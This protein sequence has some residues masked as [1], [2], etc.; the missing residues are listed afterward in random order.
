[1]KNRIKTYFFSLIFILLSASLFSNKPDSV[2]QQYCPGIS[3]IHDI[4]NF[5]YRTGIGLSVYDNERNIQLAIIPVLDVL[6]TNLPLDGPYGINTT[7]IFF[8]GKKNS[9][10]LNSFVNADHKIMFNKRISNTLN[11]KKFNTLHEITAGY[12]I[13][14]R[15]YRRLFILN[16]VNAGIVL[17]RIFSVNENKTKTYTGTEMLISFTIRYDL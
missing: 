13:E 3:F 1:M 5:G 14:V 17:D 4:S 16:S 15:V 6:K 10:S 9:S 11:D 12:G 7:A 2:K 8:F